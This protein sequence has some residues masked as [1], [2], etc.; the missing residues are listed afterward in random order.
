[1]RLSRFVVLA[2]H[3]SLTQAARALGAHQCTLT[4]Q[5]QQLERA[6]GGL[7]LHRHPHPRPVGPLT[8]LGEQLHRQALDHLQATST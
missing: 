1:L 5:L 4:N 6:C 7:L 3:P 8:P 2:E